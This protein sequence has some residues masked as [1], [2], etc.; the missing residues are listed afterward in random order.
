MIS[1]RY[2]R[3]V[4]AVLYLML[5]S[6]GLHMIILGVHSLLVRNTLDFNFFKI[7]GVDIFY[8]DFVSSPNSQHI[9]FFV[10]IGIFLFSYFFFTK[11]NK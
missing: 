8:P 3:F 11:K 2:N 1:N 5:I 7:I 4:Q 10:S 9:S 6:A